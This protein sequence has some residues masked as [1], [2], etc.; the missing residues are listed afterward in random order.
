MKIT[1]PTMAVLALLVSPVPSFAACVSDRAALII[2]HERDFTFRV[3]NP[4]GIN[5]EAL[6][7]VVAAVDYPGLKIS[8]FPSLRY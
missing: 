2:G 7:E 1:I 5:V 8:E 3:Y 4:E 6:R